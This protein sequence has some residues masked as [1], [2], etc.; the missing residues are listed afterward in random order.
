M[1]CIIE[2]TASTAQTRDTRG[3]LAA[4]RVYSLIRDHG[5]VVARVGPLYFWLPRARHDYLS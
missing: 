3:S 2:C 5:N 4:P 1:Y